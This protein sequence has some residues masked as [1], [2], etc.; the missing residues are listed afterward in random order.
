MF[1]LPADRV[2]LRT[3]IE[4]LAPPS[5]RTFLLLD[6]F[7]R[8]TTILSTSNNIIIRR[9]ERVSDE[10]SIARVRWGLP[11]TCL[12]TETSIRSANEKF[13]GQSIYSIIASSDREM[14]RREIETAKS[15]AASG[16]HGVDQSSFVYIAFRLEEP[17]SSIYPCIPSP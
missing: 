17:V 2:R 13:R 5:K 14:V 6:R 10:N 8:S 9:P 1:L 4:D 7:S 11:F 15:W 12:L 3:P 16:D